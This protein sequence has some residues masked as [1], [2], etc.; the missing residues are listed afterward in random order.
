[1]SMLER[2]ASFGSLSMIRQGGAELRIG[3]G[4]RLILTRRAGAPAG[5]SR[6]DRVFLCLD[7]RFSLNV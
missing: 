7:I 5:R 3:D 2:R 1:M 4:P 6:C